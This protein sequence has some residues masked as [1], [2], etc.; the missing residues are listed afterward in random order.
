M[1]VLVAGASGHIGLA[2][3]HALLTQGFDVIAV[4]RPSSQF[5]LQ[6]PRL[7]TLRFDDL[8]RRGWQAEIL[9]C[10]AVVSCL[11]SRTGTAEDARAVDFD[12][13]AALLDW[14]EAQNVERFMLL[15]AIC[16]QKPRLAFQFEKL[17]FEQRL[18]A[19]PVSHTIVRP[20]AFFKSLSGQLSRVQQGKPF[21][22]FGD[23]TLTACKPISADDLAGFMVQRL[24]DA[25]SSGATLPI[26]GPGPA[27]TPLDQVAILSDLI[28]RPVKTRAVSP[29]VRC[30]RRVDEAC[31]AGVG[32]G[33]Q[34][35]R[36]HANRPVLRHRV[37]V[38]V[39][40]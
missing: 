2:M 17:R 39:G 21:L 31:S 29:R 32:L 6:H 25:N 9:R 30:A 11:A 35:S 36:T 37:D 13:N 24:T 7:E 19:S 18:A 23:G 22:V 38:G 4:V 10:D 26:G 15:S 16:V 1:R 27:I 5:A 34:Q 3:V 20:T 12:A 8:R 14:A 28:G 40:R 33:P